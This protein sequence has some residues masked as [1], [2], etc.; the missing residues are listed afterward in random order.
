[1]YKWFCD[2]QGTTAEQDNRFADKKK[3]LMK[4]MR[5][6]EGVDRKVCII[7]VIICKNITNNLCYNFV[8]HKK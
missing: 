4:Q 7:N 6:G 3:K 5:F 8:L 2:L 1:M